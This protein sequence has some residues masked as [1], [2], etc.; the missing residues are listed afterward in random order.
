MPFQLLEKSPSSCGG[1]L[2]ALFWIYPREYTDQAAYN[3]AAGRT[4]A[5]LMGRY[6]SGRSGKVGL[7]AGSLALLAMTIPL[8]KSRPTVVGVIAAGVVA[9]AAHND[10]TGGAA[11]FIFFSIVSAIVWTIG[12]AIGR[13]IFAEAVKAYA[14]DPAG[15]DRDAAVEDIA[16]RYLRFI[17]S[18]VSGGEEGAR[19]EE[20]GSLTPAEP[21]GQVGDRVWI[22]AVA[23]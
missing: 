5:T 4:A 18:G 22:S 1:K 20:G 8:V 2:P 16:R 6:L 7:I 17:G 13:S 14:K 23:Y 10:P 9:V 12:F 19:G 15:F 11:N 3:A 21:G